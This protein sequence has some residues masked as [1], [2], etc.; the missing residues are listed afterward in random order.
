[1]KFKNWMSLVTSTSG[2]SFLF[3]PCRRM[4]ILLFR[5]LLHHANLYTDTLLLSIV[6][7][8]PDMS[9][10]LANDMR[11]ILA[12]T[13]ILYGETSDVSGGRCAGS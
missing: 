2:H 6:T 11:Y 12:S 1:M 9:R 5:S 4:T 3:L 8:L 7:S 13:H 10:T